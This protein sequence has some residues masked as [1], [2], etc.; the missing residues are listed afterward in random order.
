MAEFCEADEITGYGL[1]PNGQG[2]EGEVPVQG[3]HPFLGKPVRQAPG[4]RRSKKRY[5]FDFA[6]RFRLLEKS[7][8]TN[9]IGRTIN[10]SSGGVS[11]VTDEQL[12]VGANIE[13]CIEWPI[14]LN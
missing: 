10:V 3:R 4:D 7:L 1:N 2:S 12:N 9:G 14:L 5:G 13:L 6:V 11:F 8:A